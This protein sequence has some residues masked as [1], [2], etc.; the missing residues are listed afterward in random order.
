LSQ[1][2]LNTQSVELAIIPR[3]VFPNW[4]AVVIRQVQ[5]GGL[6][7]GPVALSVVLPRIGLRTNHIESDAGARWLN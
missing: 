4:D 5:R 1:R 3:I 2:G 7:I 6:Q